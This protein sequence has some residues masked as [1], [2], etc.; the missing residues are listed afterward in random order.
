VAAIAGAIGGANNGISAIPRPL[1]ETL[2]DSETI[3]AL[4]KDFYKVT[5]LRN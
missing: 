5:I 2:K 4:A 3:I 1:I